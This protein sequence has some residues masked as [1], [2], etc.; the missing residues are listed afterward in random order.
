MTPW[1]ACIGGARWVVVTV[2]LYNKRAFEKL[3]GLDK[4]DL[5]HHSMRLR[6]DPQFVHGGNHGEGKDLSK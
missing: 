2:V 6:L 4:I 3:V 5:R 1:T